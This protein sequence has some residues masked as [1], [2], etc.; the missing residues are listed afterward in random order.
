MQ[1]ILITGCSSGFG[2][3]I[4]RYFLEQ[5]W[6][7]VATMRKP[8]ETLLPASPHLRVL[9]LDV[10]RAESIQQLTEA[11]GPIDVLVNNAGVGLLAPL[12]GT[13]MEA[14]RTVFE[15]N[16]LG[17]IAMTKAFLPQFRERQAG[18]IVNITSMVTWQPYPLLSV[19]SASKTAVEGFTESLAV[20]LKGLNIRVNL[21]LPGL[22]PGTEFGNNARALMGGNVPEAYNSLI[23]AAMEKMA[24]TAEVTQVMEVAEAVWRVVND[25]DSPLRTPAGA[26]AVTTAATTPER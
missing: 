7:V 22:A 3:E 20:E 4:A 2:L 1:T 8:D 15:T 24:G 5:G 18:V 21:V 23:Q 13:E 25:A 16:T 26:D 6:K 14:A 10:T 12:E 11:A 19:Y 17:T 9:A